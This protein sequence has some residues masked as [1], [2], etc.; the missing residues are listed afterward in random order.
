MFLYILK[1]ARCC[2]C[3]RQD[4]RMLGNMYAQL[5]TQQVKT[6][7]V[8]CSVFM[9]SRHIVSCVH[10]S[11]SDKN[12]SII[13]HCTTKSRKQFAKCQLWHILSIVNQAK[14]MPFLHVQTISRS[15]PEAP[16]RRCIRH[17]HATSWLLCHPV[18]WSSWCSRAWGHMVQERAA[19]GSSEWFWDGSLPAGDRRSSG[20][21]ALWRHT[22]EVLNKARVFKGPLESFQSFNT[23][24]SNI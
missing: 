11:T 4:W 3:L 24:R 20:Q 19:A 21:K 10:N 16:S 9:V 1:V 13:R 7:R 18:M 15:H 23:N 6:K 2:S 17:G 8:F 14:I 12:N 5:P 22:L